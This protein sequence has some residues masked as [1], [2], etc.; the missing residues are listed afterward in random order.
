VSNVRKP[1]VDFLGLDLLGVGLEERHD[2]L[3]LH[4][5]EPNIEADK[6]SGRRGGEVVGSEEYRA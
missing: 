5:R 4:K 3:V 2:P 6:I 1:R